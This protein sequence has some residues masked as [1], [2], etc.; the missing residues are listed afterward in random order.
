MRFNVPVTRPWALDPGGVRLDTAGRSALPIRTGAVLGNL[1][2]V[3]C[4]GWLIN[5]CLIS[6]EN[7]LE[8]IL[9]V[10]STECAGDNFGRD[11]HVLQRGRT[12][13]QAAVSLTPFVRAAVEIFGASG[14]G[15]TEE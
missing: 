15:A 9:D 10:L 7:F 11:E 14:F 1:A 13:P 4:E 12:T 2:L 5:L 8:P 6:N 3:L